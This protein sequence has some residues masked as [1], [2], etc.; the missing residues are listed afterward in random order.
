M[1]CHLIILERMPDIKKAQQNLWRFAEINDRMVYKYLLNMMDTSA[2]YMY[3]L[4][5]Q[6]C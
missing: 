1:V 4:K 6:V 2:D 3:I 5:H